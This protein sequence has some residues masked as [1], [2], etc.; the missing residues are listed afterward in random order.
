LKTLSL[1]YYLLIFVETGSLVRILITL[2]LLHC[3]QLRPFF[4]VPPPHGPSWV[5]VQPLPATA[6]SGRSRYLKQEPTFPLVPI[7][8]P[9]LH[10]SQI[11]SLERRL[12]PTSP[13]TTD[14]RSEI[15]HSQNQ[16]P[17]IQMTIGDARSQRRRRAPAGCCY[18]SAV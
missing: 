16:P 5:N 8:R 13:S 1:F 12:P 14:R 3:D 7:P 18:D 9:P 10:S 15:C 11:R 17:P 4:Q 6:T 2:W